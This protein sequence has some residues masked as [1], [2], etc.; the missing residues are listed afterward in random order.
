MAKFDLYVPKLKQVDGYGGPEDEMWADIPGY[1]GKYLISTYGRVISLKRNGIAR[2]TLVALCERNRYFSVA[3]RNKNRVK[4]SVHR[5]VAM[6]FIPNPKNLPQV[7]H[8]DGNRYNNHVSNLRWVTAME[9]HHNPITVE[10]K[11]RSGVARRNTGGNKCVE[12]RDKSGQLIATYPSL[13]EAERVTGICQSNISA[14]ARGKRIFAT[15]H[16]AT[17]R[18]AGGYLWN[19]A[20]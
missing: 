7:D 13:H 4:F 20:K 18:S 5:L 17:V 11:K 16:W 15:D 9:N 1:E 8:I 3:L 2:D 19:F 6:T 12:Q 10:S 14:A